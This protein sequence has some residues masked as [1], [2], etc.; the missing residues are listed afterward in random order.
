MTKLTNLHE[1]HSGI[2]SM[3]AD[4]SKIANT[5]FQSAVVLELSSAFSCLN[6][7]RQQHVRLLDTVLGELPGIARAT[8][9]LLRR[10]HSSDRTIHEAE[11][12]FKS[13][14]AQLAA[15]KAVL[16]A[17]IA[18]GEPD[19]DIEPSFTGDPD[20]DAMLRD[21]FGGD[22]SS[23]NIET[24][25]GGGIEFIVIGEAGDGE[26]EAAEADGAV[27]VPPQIGD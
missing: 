7:T 20:L 21:L 6:C 17:E 5:F 2:A 12:N 24:T 27:F 3:A 8:F 4:L 11:A 18:R 10:I 25:E 16:E 14:A 22:P 19:E 26:I 1:T 23:D 9:A 13:L 15:R